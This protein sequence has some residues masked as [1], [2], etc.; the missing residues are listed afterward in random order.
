MHEFELIKNYFQKLSIKSHSALNLNDDVFFD[1]KNKLVVSVDTYTEGNHFIDFKKPELVI[2]KIIRS[3]ISDLICKGVKPK[4]YFISASGNK[5]SFSK[6]NLSK[7][8]KS[9]N[10][11]QNKYKIF[12]S[13]GDT[14]FSSKLSFTITSIGFANNIVYRNK[15]KINDDI[16][17]SGNLGDS[18]LGLLVLNNKLKLN[19]QFRKYFTN[20]YFM[21]NIQLKLADQINNFANTSID[22]SDGLLADLDKMINNQKL[23]YKLFLDDIPISNNLKKI[24]DLK[25]LSKIDHI[26]NGD[27][28]QVLFTAS[29]NKVRII[30]NFAS[31]C[32]VKLTKIGSIQSHVEKS[33]II[34][35]KNVQISLKNKGYFHKF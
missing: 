27:D 26:S 30:K 28:Y 32:R 22:I 10:Q 29:K 7:I 4:Y 31:N 23:S 14:V 2:K 21:P 24:L 6:S 19:Q 11:E 12:L 5:K 8:S 25:K 9:L 1:K 20:H 13:G 35:D 33:S 34:N 18:Y 17:V 16:Y 3:S 15:A